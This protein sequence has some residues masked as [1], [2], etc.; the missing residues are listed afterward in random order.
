MQNFT[1][2]DTLGTFKSFI[3]LA[4]LVFAPGYV[5]GWA[6]D[7]FEFRQ[8][9]PLLRLILAVP[10]TV[11]IC[12]MLSY[13]LAR[14][15]APGLWIFYL[16]AFAACVLLLAKQIR[17]ASL[18]AI[19]RPVWIAVGL[20]AF[21]VL[22]AT[23]SMVDLQLGDRLYPP[24]TAFDHSTRVE[25]MAAIVRH[26]PPHNPFFVHPFVELRY[27]YLWML[28]CSLPMKF[29]H[30]EVRHLMYAG[31]VWCGISLMCVIALGLKF[32][33][34]AE[35]G[36]AAQALVG[37]LLLFVT[38]LD[39]LPTLYLGLSQKTWL[40]DMEWWND[41]QI[42]SW[43]G[44]LLWVPHHVAGL[45]A[46]F[47]GFLLLR[48]E[49]DA[50]RRRFIVPAIVAG[51][52]FASAAG[53]SVYVTL[54]F[55]VAIALWL[56][57][58]AARKNW[59]EASLFCCS[60]AVALVWALP[61]LFSLRGSIAGTAFAELTI[62]EFSFAVD[63]GHRLGLIHSDSADM[64]TCA[65]LLPV[66]YALELGFYLAIGILRLRRLWRGRAATSTN[67]LAAWTV[68]LS[69]FLL[70]TFFRSTTIASND[71]GW[72][73][74]LPA[75]LILLLWA[76]NMVYE[77]WTKTADAASRPSSSLRLTLASLLIL[78]VL[79]TTYQVVMLRI[80]PVLYDRG[81]VNGESWIESDRQFGQRTY[82]L[83]SAYEA[84][85][86]QLPASAVVQNN[87]AT[88]D[89]IP[90][91]LY[92]THDAVAGG[93]DCGVSFGGD[94]KVCHERMQRLAPLFE[95]GTGNP[96]EVCRDL[97]IDVLVVQDNDAAWQDPSSWIW[98]TPPLVANARVRAFRCGFAGR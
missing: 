79:G 39:I 46:C 95:D 97:G 21:W 15:F 88:E 26:T 11:A 4:P 93:M 83:R 7:L 27:H 59:R 29:A 75:Q 81:T 20:I 55:V 77:W 5:A 78:G 40:S 70:G 58:L 72:R 54:T 23:A 64:L 44:S 37:I 45:I 32:L 24:I 67:E 74:L 34:R 52:A 2:A 12:P 94:E 92:S 96:D 9:R 86:V 48:H 18:Q 65:L 6:L 69:S 51:M 41:A 57:I 61:Y 49:M 38:G 10:L 56:L 90:H 50:P 98:R 16:A 87:P 84:L 31:I 17:S 19:T 85:N 3:A 14:F 66:N 28:V 91:S 8:R 82:A 73:C 53:M 89:P 13:L 63:L 47:L 71:L 1:V 35:K 33:L 80:Y 22:L 43:I 42:T 36:I 62:R 25:V 30:L 68:V 76:A 60:G